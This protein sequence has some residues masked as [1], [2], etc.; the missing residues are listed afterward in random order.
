LVHPLL[1][2]KVA[3]IIHWRLLIIDNSDPE[4]D[5]EIIDHGRAIGG[6]LCESVFRTDL[7]G[8]SAISVVGKARNHFV[9][10]VSDDASHRARSTWELF[11]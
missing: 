2:F 4:I 8:H 7:S 1:S 3:S 11:V 10:G 9:T 6:T 5:F